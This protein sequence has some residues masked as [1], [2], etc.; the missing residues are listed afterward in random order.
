MERCSEQD[1]RRWATILMPMPF[2]DK[3]WAER[4]S[5]QYHDGKHVPFLKLFKDNLMKR[6]L[7]K[8]TEE[9]RE[10]WNER[11]ETAAKNQSYW[12]RKPSRR[13]R[14]WVYAS[15]LLY[16]VQSIRYPRWIR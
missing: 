15:L 16:F 7:W 5:T 4:F 14:D 8:K 3:H 2:C 12:V 11:C 9:S 10:Q 1:C 6:G 13:H